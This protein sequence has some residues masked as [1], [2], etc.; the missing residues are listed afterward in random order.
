MELRFRVLDQTAQSVIDVIAMVSDPRGGV[1]ELV[2][3]RFDDVRA[4]PTDYGLSQNFPNPFNPETQIAFQVPESG[5]L[6]L[7]IYNTL[8]QQVRVLE[9][10]PVEAGFHRVVWDGRDAVGRN[11]SSGVYLVRMKS[12]SFNSIKKMLLLK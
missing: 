12:G 11:V 3:A 4:V 5:N 10:G 2:G 9:Q 6:S 7:V 1:A 8:G